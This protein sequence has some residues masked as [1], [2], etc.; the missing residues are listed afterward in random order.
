[1]LVLH[2]FKSLKQLEGVATT[3]R[4]IITDICRLI[5]LWFLG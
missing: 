3:S 4:D 2:L 5:E 1:M